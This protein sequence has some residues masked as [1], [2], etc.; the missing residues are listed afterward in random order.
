M[1]TAEA[2]L[3]FLQTKL[4]SGPQITKDDYKYVNVKQK[5]EIDI[6]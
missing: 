3:V 6:Y 1:L 2:L 4:K 5:H